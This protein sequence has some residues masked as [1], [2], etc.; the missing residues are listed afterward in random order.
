MDYISADDG[1]DSSR[2]YG[3]TDRRT[4]HSIHSPRLGMGNK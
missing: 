1:V 2:Q 4:D 3:Q